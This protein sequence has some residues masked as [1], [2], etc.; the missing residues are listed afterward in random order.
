MNAKYVGALIQRTFSKQALRSTER[1]KDF[2]F[3]VGNLNTWSN[4]KPQDSFH[5]DNLPKRGGAEYKGL[6][7]FGNKKKKIMIF[8][9]WQKKPTCFFPMN[10]NSK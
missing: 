1:W 4:C 10:L 9:F 6:K 2:R 8:F 7:L 3:N 5:I